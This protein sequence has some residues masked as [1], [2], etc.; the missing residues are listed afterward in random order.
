MLYFLIKI[1]ILVT[2]V[3]STELKCKEDWSNIED[4]FA[5]SYS[6]DYMSGHC[7]GNAYKLAKKLLAEPAV[8]PN[9]LYIAYAFPRSGNASSIYARGGRSGSE[10]WEY[11]VFVIY[12][13]KVMD[14]DHESIASIKNISK[15]IEDMYEKE[16]PEKAMIEGQHLF[17]PRSDTLFRLIPAKDYVE[18][19]LRT[20]SGTLDYRSYIS[21][22][23]GKYPAMQIK[24]LL[25]KF[26]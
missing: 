20:E 15:Y 17:E 11:H 24:D 21:D 6:C 16:I 23:E 7:Y 26:L 14:H 3:E 5:K 10:E 12:K 13:G 9:Q 19:T 18:N 2:V 4:T 8:D 25:Q 22:R 1:V